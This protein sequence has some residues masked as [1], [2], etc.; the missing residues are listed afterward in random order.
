[1]KQLF[2]QDLL[3]QWDIAIEDINMGDFDAIGEFTAKKTRNPNSDL[4][5]SVGCFFRPNYERGILIYHLVKK[6]KIESMLE[7]GF[8][9]GYST[10]CAAKAMTDCGIR[11]KITTIDPNLDEE[12]LN[13]LAK[14]F[15]REWFDRINFVQARSQTFLAS[16]DEKYDF[17]YI[18]GDHRFES[19]KSDWENSKDRFNKFVLFDDYYLPTKQVKDI[20]CAKLIDNIEGFKK[21]LIMMDRRIFFDDRRIPDEEIDYGQVLLSREG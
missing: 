17:I 14:R 20:E 13:N 9:R 8:G 2:I 15:P 1:M 11:G 6:F 16:S 12:F 19:V 10:F 21:Q 5:K 7:I 18:D 3:K 4:Y